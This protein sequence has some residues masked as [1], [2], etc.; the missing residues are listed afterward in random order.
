[1]KIAV[2]GATSTVGRL[3]VEQALAEG[4]QVTAFTRS[5][6]GLTQRHERLDIVEGDVLDSNSV[7]RAVAGQDAVLVSLGAGRKGV[8]RA[9]GTRAV[10]EAMNRTGVKRLIVQTTLGV[11]DSKANLNFLWKYVMFGILLR[12]A[13]A[14][15]VQ[16]EA[17]VRASDLDWTIV[18]P[19][20]FTD[21]PR[22]GGFRR[23]F[24]AGER[25]LSLKITRADIA[26]FMLEQLT[27]T[28]YLRQAPGISN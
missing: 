27:D 1:M 28:T 14:D 20:A 25:G 15:H 16:Q 13:F 18:R 22:T 8:I 26:D 21:G 4:H 5:A 19:S 6:A 9:E 24:P 10:I 7:Q 12:Q 23:G 2:F 17:Y 3:V 11:G